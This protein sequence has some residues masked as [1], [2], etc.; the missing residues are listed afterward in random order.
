MK[1]AVLFSI[2]IVGIIYVGMFGIPFFRSLI[3][4]YTE[5]K[6]ISTQFQQD[7]EK[8]SAPIVEEHD[9]SDFDNDGLN[10]GE[11]KKYL[12]HTKNSDTDGDGFSDKMEVEK[13][14]DPLSPSTDSV[15]LDLDSLILTNGIIDC[16]TNIYCFEKVISQCRP[17][18]ANTT[19]IHPIYWQARKEKPYFEGVERVSF[20]IIGRE[21]I[22]Q[23]EN[24]KEEEKHCLYK[25]KI[26]DVEVYL[27][28]DALKQEGVSSEDIT[29]FI[30]STRERL[31]NLFQVVEEKSIC[32]K[33]YEI[34]WIIAG[35]KEKPNFYQEFIN[36]AARCY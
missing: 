36:A 21:N 16:G 24:L 9:N 23:E 25:I 34:L 15:N 19:N 31:K 8:H 26:Q 11:E 3:R 7:R 2:L 5:G 29:F 20:E 10:N 28:N 1:K 13:G 6:E 32:K 12:T 35:R 22:I 27:I 17:A 4:Q 30:N 18:R 33:T 14:F